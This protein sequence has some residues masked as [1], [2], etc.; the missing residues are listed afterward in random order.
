M[1]KGGEAGA[2]AAI[3]LVANFTKGALPPQFVKDY[4]AGSPVY[5]LVWDNIAETADRYNE[6]GKFTTFIGFE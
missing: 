6:P 2:L 5:A 1:Q 3:D 4:S